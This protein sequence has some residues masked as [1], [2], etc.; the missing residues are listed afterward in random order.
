MAG[1]LHGLATKEGKDLSLPQAYQPISL[2]SVDY[3]ILTS[4]LLSWLMKICQEFIGPE[5]SGFL[6]GRHM[7]D[8][9][10]RVIN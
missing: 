1:S 6:K 8:C 7:S 3:K 5:Q 9:I 10:Q 2:L 4:I